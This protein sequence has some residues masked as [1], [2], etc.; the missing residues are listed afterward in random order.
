[1]ND[2]IGKQGFAARIAALRA[3]ADVSCRALSRA[4]GLAGGHVALIEAGKLGAARGLEGPTLR[5]LARVLATSAEY[6]RDGTG[7]A[8]APDAVKRAVARALARLKR[9]SKAPTVEAA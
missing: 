8:P 7:E 5:K 2:N 4:A 3:L 6:L 9:T 1:M